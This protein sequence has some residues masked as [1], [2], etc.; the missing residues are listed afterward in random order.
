MDFVDYRE[1][2][3][4]G[5]NDEQ[6]FQVFLTKTFNMLNIL[7]NS[8]HGTLDYE[9]YER[10]CMETGSQMDVRYTSDYSGEQ[11]FAHCIQILDSHRRSLPEFLS[12]FIWFA[13]SV[14]KKR[15]TYETGWVRGKYIQFI[16]QAFD[17]CHIPFDLMSENGQY[18]IFPKGAVELDNALVSDVLTWLAN[19]PKAH[20]TYCI[21]LKQYADGIYIR[22]TADNFRKALEE[23]CQEFLGNTKNLAN[24]ITE[25]FQYLGKNNAE[26]EVASMMR[27]LMNTYDTL[28]NKIAKH[29][30]KVDEKYLEFLMYQTGVFIRMLI[31]VDQAS[32][33]V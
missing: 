31:V 2:L 24:N 4:I 14:R 6:K 33:G 30:D 29:N 25:V 27:S 28:N 19:Y 5:F 16:T 15:P 13:N 9:E 22:D 11:R 3:G 8:A 32:K 23:F 7:A 21:A 10:F 26:P 18:F 20:K 12:Y 1:R 17:E